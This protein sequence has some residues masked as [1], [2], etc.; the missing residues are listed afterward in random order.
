MKISV[1]T[2]AFNDAKM[3]KSTFNNIREI[4]G[5]IH[6]YILVDGGSQDGTHELIAEYSDVISKWVS[7][8]ENLVEA[9]KEGLKNA[10]LEDAKT[11]KQNEVKAN[12]VRAE[13]IALKNVVA[14]A[15]PA[16]EV[17]AEG[18]SAE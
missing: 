18:E 14:A 4:K 13:K 2:V 3:L 5:Q 11:R 1:I 9:K 10:K 7:E 15:E 12:T 6:E 8:K 16:A 17:E